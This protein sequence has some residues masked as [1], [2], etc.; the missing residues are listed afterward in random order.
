MSVSFA[1]ESADA[2]ITAGNAEYAY[3]GASYDIYDASD[4]SLAAQIVTGEDG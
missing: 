2:S 3:S 4:D 1:K